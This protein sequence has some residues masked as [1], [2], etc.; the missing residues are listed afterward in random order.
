MKND[1]VLG[2]PILNRSNIKEKETIGMFISTIPI[3]INIDEKLT[4]KEFVEIVSKE[5]MIY[6]KNQKYPYELILHDFRETHNISDLLFDV[7]ISY[8]NASFDK[9]ISLEDYK[10]RW[11]F[12]ENQVESLALHIND[13][14]NEG[15]FIL[16]LDYRV[17]VFAGDEIIKL[18]EHFMNIIEDAVDNPAK[19]IF[20]LDILSEWEKNKLLYEF[21]NTYTN[22]PREKTIHE[23]FQEQVE[24]TPDNIA[25]VFGDKELTYREL[26]NSSNQVARVLRDKGVKPDTIVGI[27]VERSIEMMVGILGILKAGGAYLPIDPEYPEDRI[28]FM[29]NDSKTKILLTQNSLTK[30]MVFD[31]ELIFLDDKKLYYNNKTNLD[32]INSMSDLIYVIYTSG[33]TGQPKGVMI[34]HKSVCNFIYS[35]FS[36]YEKDINSK[37]ICLN[38]ANISFD[39]SVCEIFLPILFGAKLLLLPKENILDL[40][41]LSKIILGNKVTFLYIPPSI[42]SDLLNYFKKFQQEVNINKIL[43]GVEPIKKYVLEEYIRL[44]KNI[45]IINGYGPT[46][47]T[48]CSTFFKYYSEFGSDKYIDDVKDLLGDKSKST[49]IL[50]SN[51]P[52]GKP[53]NNYKS[54]ILNKKHQINPIGVVGELYI[55][56]IGLSRGYLNKPELTN[57]KFICNPFNSSEIV[58]KTGDLVKWLPDGNIEFIGR[59]DNQVKIKGFRI[60]LGEIEAL[61][62]SYPS[63]KQ[64]VVIAKDNKDYA[65]KYLCAYFVSDRKFNDQDIRKLK[66][67]MKKF[68]PEYMI[69]SYF[70]QILNL[71]ITANGKINKQHLPDPSYNIINNNI[72][73]PSN[74]I[75]IKLLEIIKNSLVI[76]NI[77]VSDNIF[78]FGVDSLILMRIV[79]MTSKYNWNLNVQDFYQFNNVK[80][81]A[82]KIKLTIESPLSNSFDTTNNILNEITNYVSNTIITDEHQINNGDKIIFNKVFLTGATGFLGAHILNILLDNSNAQIFC[83]VRDKNNDFETRFLS[84]LEYYFPDKYLTQ[85]NDRIHIINGDISL[86][87]F[88]LPQ[89]SYEELG[90]KIDLVI[91]CAALTKHFGDDSEF[92][93]VNLFGTKEIINFCDEFKIKLGYI[94]T[95]SVSGDGLEQKIR[96]LKFTENDFYINQNILENPYIRSKFEAENIVLKALE[97]GLDV[98]VFRV[99]NLTARYTDKK[100]QINKNENMFYNILKAIIKIGAVPDIMLDIALKFTPV[101]YCS[102]AI[103]KILEKPIIENRIFHLVNHNVIKISE[104]LQILK[105]MNITISVLHNYSFDQYRD[106]ILNLN[107][108]KEHS[109]EEFMLNYMN[110]FFDNYMVEVRSEITIVYLKKLGFEWPHIDGSYIKY[111]IYPD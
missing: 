10:G 1:I 27:M 52:I 93:K 65:N 98:A 92:N 91:H 69:P 96:N 60:E 33:S 38:L 55:S 85:I 35:I 77:G 72:E 78:D 6:L 37:D 101:D 58:Y 109:P 110:I 32:N 62:S 57:E 68:L 103:L 108:M 2:T 36:S 29:I 75:E 9:T 18:H 11:H 12:N 15:Q 3:R 28:R 21:N 31:S 46:E 105:S 106:Y 25:V 89:K 99:G 42:L 90:N 4:F 88:G 80:E 79:S 40:S 81:I 111:F 39:V 59:I 82:K 83:L 49:N 54:Y 44:N 48:I 47:C 84:I 30:K 66:L 17:D 56:G 61:L 13:R 107:L 86:E 51:V 71:P 87:R 64:A 67:N 76:K 26:N 70:I 20:E 94:S 74:D 104:L 16:N 23:L 100:F 45:K 41:L 53:L 22:Y 95:T 5:L 14:E 73:N 102:I 34:E 24:R 43:V 19:K 7:I 97:N 63:I 8:Q 50:K